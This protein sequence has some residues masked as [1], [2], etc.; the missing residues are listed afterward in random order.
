LARALPP[1]SVQLFGAYDVRGRFPE[2]FPS[3]TLERLAQALLREVRGPFLVGRDTRSESARLEGGI[4][5]RFRAARRPVVRL[6]VQ[7]TPVIGFASRKWQTPALAFTPSHNDLGYAGIKAFGPTGRS[8]G[9]EWALIRR[10][11]FDE[12]EQ[13][14]SRPPSDGRRTPRR[15]APPARKKVVEEYLG[16]V[17]RGLHT[18]LTVVTD[19]RGGATTLLAPRALA[20]VGARVVQLHPRISPTFHGVS[21]EPRPNDVAELGRTVRA[22]RADLGV[23]FDGDGDRVAFVDDHGRWVEPEVIGMFLYRNLSSPDR[24]LVVSADASYRCESAARTVRSRV[25]S[26]FVVAAMRRAGSWVGFEASSHYYLRRWGSESDGI[27]VACV[28]CHL[29][30]QERTSLGELR[31]RFGPILR[32]RQL[33]EFRTRNEAVRRFRELTHALAPLLRKGT[34]GFVHRSPRGSIIVRLSNTQPAIRVVFE[35]DRGQR[36]GA[37]R[38]FWSQEL[39]RRRIICAGSREGGLPPKY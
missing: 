3:A 13:T 17:S 12:P 22:R 36:L 14:R 16:H 39:A 1:G 37:L 32:S 38:Q 10:H 2:E 7:P 20:R 19:G 25:G 8:F 35:A 11:F 21:P 34:D 23:A 4:V 6:G 5:R 33:L 31:R 9:A 15:P 28:V 29:L 30:E 24:P 26:R 27:L 18:S